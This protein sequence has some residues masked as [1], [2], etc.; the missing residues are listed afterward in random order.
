M[1]AIE[2]L[3][4][5]QALEELESIVASLRGNNCDVDTLAARTARAAA[6]LEAC[7]TRL[8]LTETQLAEI[9]EK[10]ES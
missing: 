7:R 2:D 9:L 8:T 1:T 10:L 5:S 6:L 4:Y 3:S